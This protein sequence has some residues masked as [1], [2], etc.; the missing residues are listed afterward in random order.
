MNLGARRG[1]LR[2]RMAEAG[3]DALLI[4]NLPDVH[5]LCG[6]SGSN[7]GLLVW[8]TGELLAT[9]GR[10]VTQAAQESPGVEVLVTRRIIPALLEAAPVDAVG[11]DATAV[12]V[13]EVRSARAEV[14]AVTLEPADVDVS[15]LRQIKDA[16]EIAAL[17]QACRI[18][19][20][21]LSELTAQI[22]VGMNE[23]EIARLLELIMGR[24]GAA[25]RSFDSIVAT[26]PHSAIPHHQPT[27]RPIAAGDL[28]KIDFGA[29]YGGYH[30]DCTRTFIVAADP[31]PWQVEIHAVVAKAQQA[32]IDALR[33]GLTGQQADATARTV[34]DDAGFGQFYGHGLGHGVGLEIHEVPFLGPTSTHTVEAGVPLTVEPGIYLPDRGGVRIEDTLLVLDDGTRILTDFPRDLAR[35]G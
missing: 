28:L 2:E 27:L 18:S 4:T 33:P 23:L 8:A 17:E 21:A 26:G 31:Q 13:A 30:A 3:F 14:P 6:F 10:Y 34:I 9:D 20:D 25:D 5:Y 29:L 24:H 22:R 1:R 11:F 7:A 35:V 19:T 15:G 12:T 16:D 32:G